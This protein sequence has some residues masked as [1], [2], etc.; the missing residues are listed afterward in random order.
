MVNH[1]CEPLNKWMS[2]KKDY[3]LKPQGLQSFILFVLKLF[4]IPLYA[5]KLRPFKILPDPL[6]VIFVAC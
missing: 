4:L 6:K 1:K 2:L 5:P 3:A